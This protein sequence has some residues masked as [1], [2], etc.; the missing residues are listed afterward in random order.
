MDRQDVAE[1][2]AKPISRELLGSSIPA[3]PVSSVLRPPPWKAQSSWR[4][5][6]S[7]ANLRAV[8]IPGGR[9]GFGFAVN[10]R[11]NVRL[12][13]P[14][15]RRIRPVEHLNRPRRS[16]RRPQPPDASAKL[17]DVETRRELVG[18]HR[19]QSGTSILAF[20]TS[21][22]TSATKRNLHTS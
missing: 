22:K 15:D 13:G 14:A 7:S 2:L 6:G 16:R 4:T 8:F 11:D 17:T 12:A 20:S 18:S 3:R 5:E 9:I 19:P 1:V 21:A 10:P